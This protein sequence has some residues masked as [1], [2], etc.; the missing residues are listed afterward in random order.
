MHACSEDADIKIW[1]AGDIQALADKTGLEGSPTIV[2]HTLTPEQKRKGEIFSGD[3]DSI[4]QTLLDR[5]KGKN[6]I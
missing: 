5:L 1:N 6:I 4:V 2:K 3:K